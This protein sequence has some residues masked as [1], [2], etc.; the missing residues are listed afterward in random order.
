MDMRELKVGDNI[1]QIIVSPLI[2]QNADGAPVT[3]FFK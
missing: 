2:Y 1:N 3:V